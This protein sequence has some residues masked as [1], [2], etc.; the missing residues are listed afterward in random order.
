[1]AEERRWTIEKWGSNPQAGAINGPETEQ[2]EVFPADHP[3]LLS[4]EEAK[5]YAELIDDA[6][7]MAPVWL[8]IPDLVAKE[9]LRDRL[10]EYAGEQGETDRG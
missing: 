8:R 1:M 6:I 5:Q 9:A 4:P 7:R 3:G 10:S 2:V